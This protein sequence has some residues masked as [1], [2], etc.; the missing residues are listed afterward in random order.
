[1]PQCRGLQPVNCFCKQ[2]LRIHVCTAHAVTWQQPACGQEP[3]APW[4]T[5][6]HTHTHLC[7]EANPQKPVVT[8]PTP[9]RCVQWFASITVCLTLS[10]GALQLGWPAVWRWTCIE[11]R[12]LACLVGREGS[13]GSTDWIQTVPW[14][15]GATSLPHRAFPVVGTTQTLGLME[16]HTSL[17]TPHSPKVPPLRRPQVLQAGPS[18]LPIEDLGSPVPLPL[19]SPAWG[20]GRGGQVVHTTGGMFPRAPNDRA[21]SGQGTGEGVGEAL[22][23]PSPGNRTRRWGAKSRRTK[24]SPSSNQHHTAEEHRSTFL[25][26]HYPPRRDAKGKTKSPTKLGG[27]QPERERK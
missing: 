7:A 6:R 14:D 20:E 18:C 21:L 25:N 8:R 1:M 26:R 23:G 5:Q 9:A 13:A 24:T 27:E 11:G 15:S 4:D 19:P 2:P 16:N 10:P 22:T 3:C 17:G 12:P